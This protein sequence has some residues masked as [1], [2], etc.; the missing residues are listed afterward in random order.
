MYTMNE[1]RGTRTPLLVGRSSLPHTENSHAALST[2]SFPSIM[3]KQSHLIWV[4]AQSLSYPSSKQPLTFRIDTYPVKNKARNNNN[5]TPRSKTSLARPNAPNKE[6]GR[7]QHQPPPPHTPR[8]PSP[9]RRRQRQTRR[10]R[11]H[12]DNRR[13]RGTTP[14]PN[15]FP[16]RSNLPHHNH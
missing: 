2:C 3:Q 15:P 4:I 9:I 7:Q 5:N 10:S 12:H 8:P 6:L 13:R 1:F 16:L 11:P 14:P